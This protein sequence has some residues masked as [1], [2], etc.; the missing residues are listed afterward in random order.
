MLQLL[1]LVFF[2]ILACLVITNLV[3]NLIH[4]G[5][6]SQRG[7]TGWSATPRVQAPLPHPEM[8]DSSGKM[9]K[10]PLM[11][12]RSVTMDDVRTK[13]DAIFEASPGQPDDRD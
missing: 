12:M 11:V 5:T 4:F 7:S 2:A 13:L 10:E 3:R 9:I 1:Y 8:L 6:E